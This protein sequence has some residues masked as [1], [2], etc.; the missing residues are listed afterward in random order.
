MT[1]DAQDGAEL[2]VHLKDRLLDLMPA[3]GTAA[4][5]FLQF[6]QYAGYIGTTL[7]FGIALTAQI[8]RLLAA[9]AVK[10]R[11][12]IMLREVEGKRQ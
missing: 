11:A 1:D 5:V 4:F 9:R 2:A 12:D 10:R 6:W 3:G 8:Y 7:M